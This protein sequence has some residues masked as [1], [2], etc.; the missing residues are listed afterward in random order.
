MAT[1]LTMLIAAIIR[2]VACGSCVIASPCDEQLGLVDSSGHTLMRKRNWQAR[3]GAS[4]FHRR[5]S[6]RAS[7]WRWPSDTNHKD[8][9]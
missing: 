7:V 2:I 3:S 4:H 9:L 8:A 6:K 5:R 1:G